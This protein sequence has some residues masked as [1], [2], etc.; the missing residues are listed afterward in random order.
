MTTDPL[1]DTPK[2]DGRYS[3]YKDS[4]TSQAYQ[5]YEEKDHYRRAD[6]YL[7]GDS[8]DPKTYTVGIASVDLQK[9]RTHHFAS[10]Y[11]ETG[12]TSLDQADASPDNN[13]ADRN[14]GRA[15]I[16][17]AAKDIV[18]YL[19][20]PEHAQDKIGVTGFASAPGSAEGN[21][22][23]SDKRAAEGNAAL[24]EEIRKLNPSMVGRVNILEDGRG[25]N[26]L[27]IKTLKENKTNRRVEI[28]AYNDKDWLEP[29]RVDNI[30]H[31]EAKDFEP[32]QARGNR[33]D[34][35]LT[36]NKTLK[37]DFALYNPV[38]AHGSIQFDAAPDKPLDIRVKAEHAADFTFRV[39]DLENTKYRINDDQSVTV[40]VNGKDVAVVH[41]ETLDGKLNAQDIR[42][43]KVGATPAEFTSAAYDRSH[44]IE[45][46]VAKINVN[47]DETISKEEILAYQKKQELHKTIASADGLEKKDGT[48]DFFELRSK[49]ASLDNQFGLG[50][51]QELLEEAASIGGRDNAR[52]TQ[53]TA[54]Q[55]EAAKRQDALFDELLSNAGF[56]KPES[57]PKEGMAVQQFAQIEKGHV[58][59][60]G[61]L[62][63]LTAKGTSR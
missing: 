44:E 6:I 19:S 17:R 11:Y 3:L 26:D 16:T 37:N 62:D 7:G 12:K 29:T 43:G 2:K 36:G 30:V 55:M 51:G 61:D 59:K 20:Q 9:R 53:V 49:A 35:D 58:A 42:V 8:A 52:N 27:A 45:K 25:E 39:S 14:D 47:G 18:A 50:R 40:T 46:L 31:I 33:F 21:Q 10:V 54:K 23:L 24:I 63:K 4:P 41:Y 48:V 15:E 1:E 28:Y 57:I 13:K 60:G 22:K 34:L 5:I 38:P 56:D 32:L